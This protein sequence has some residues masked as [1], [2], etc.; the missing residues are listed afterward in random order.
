MHDESVD[1]IEKYIDTKVTISKKVGE[2]G[3]SVAMAKRARA[4]QHRYKG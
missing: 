1:L 4:N 2:K 3:M